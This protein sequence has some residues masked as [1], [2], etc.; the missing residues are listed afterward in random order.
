M[1]CVKDSW[2]QTWR[3][4]GR[5]S[6][7]PELLESPRTSPEVPRTSPEVFGDFPGSSLTVELNSNPEVPRKFPRLP[8]KFPGL[9]R[10]FP[11]LPRRSAVSLGSLT[12][13]SDS[14]R[15]SL[16][17]VT[18]GTKHYRW[19]R[20]D[21]RMNLLRNRS[22]YQLIY[23]ER[24]SQNLRRNCICNDGCSAYIPT[25]MSLYWEYIY[26]RGAVCICNLTWVATR[27]LEYVKGFLKRGFCNL[28]WGGGG[29]KGGWGRAGP[30]H[31]KNPVGKTPSTLPRR[32]H[33]C[34]ASGLNG[35][36][37]LLW[38]PIILLLR[39]LLQSDEPCRKK[40]EGSDHEHWDVDGNYRIAIEVIW[41]T[42]AAAKHE[43]AC[44]RPEDQM[45]EMKLQLY[46][47]FSPGPVAKR[48]PERW[49]AQSGKVTER[50]ANDMSVTFLTLSLASNLLPPICSNLT[51]R[52]F[53]LLSCPTTME[54]EAWTPENPGK[55]LK[56][57]GVCGSTKIS[58]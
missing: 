28:A 56:G 7:S 58:P 42:V 8:R 47:R 37:N 12:P 51:F 24:E 54:R 13:S 52:S 55:S 53:I 45:S 34:N 16:R 20:R 33:V 40:G 35:M 57:Q 3:V 26:I 32:V 22:L 5:E 38:M 30:L 39:T 2:R 6:G 50:S 14:Q 21:D 11:G 49:Y 25:N 44:M 27:V 31:F 46:E 17:L 1:S 29:G 36:S 48:G 43:V 9:P 41:V 18:L 10:K 19:S 23:T 15:L 4:A